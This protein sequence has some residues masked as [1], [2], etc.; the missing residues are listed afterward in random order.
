MSTSSSTLKIE[1]ERF[2]K[3]YTEIMSRFLIEKASVYYKLPEKVTSCVCKLP[4]YC[5]LRILFDEFFTL[6]HHGVFPFLKSEIT[7]LLNTKAIDYNNWNEMWTVVMPMHMVGSNRKWQSDVRRRLGGIQERSR[8]KAFDE[9]TFNEQSKIAISDL[10]KIKY[11]DNCGIADEPRD[12][13]S[14]FDLIGYAFE[15]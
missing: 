10:I 14:T 6:L 8:K 3:L 5:D 4:N 11:C 13:E 2:L 12:Y 1:V 7:H 15:I 9:L